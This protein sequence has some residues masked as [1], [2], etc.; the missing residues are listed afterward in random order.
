M[1]PFEGERRRA[2]DAR[3]GSQGSATE[4]ASLHTAKL[5]SNIRPLA[6]VVCMPGGAW[7]DL[8]GKYDLQIPAALRVLLTQYASADR[9]GTWRDRLTDRNKSAAF[10]AIVKTAYVRSRMED[11][12]LEHLD[13]NRST[14]HLAKH[15]RKVCIQYMRFL[16]TAVHRP[17]V[18]FMAEHRQALTKHPRNFSCPSALGKEPTTTEDAR[19]RK[20]HRGRD[21]ARFRHM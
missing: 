4:V 19:A 3:R 21:I 10:A 13:M 11:W 18:I 14:A 6:T 7:Q 2:A 12:L 15:A 1:G 17:V 9:G 16:Q 20:R 8:L 5:T